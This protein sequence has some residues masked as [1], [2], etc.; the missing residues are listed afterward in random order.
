MNKR[1]LRA[2]SGFAI[3]F[4]M[5]MSFSLQSFASGFDPVYYAE[6][7][8]DVAAAVGKSQQALTVRVSV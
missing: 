1:I 3:V 8:P 2:I 4:V 6:K 7:Y 5:V